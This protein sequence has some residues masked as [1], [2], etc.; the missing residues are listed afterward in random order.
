MAPRIALLDVRVVLLVLAVAL[1][2]PVGALT[3]DPGGGRTLAPVAF[4]DT[5]RTG[6]TGVDVRQATAAGH[7]IPRAEVFYS[8]YRYV[9]GYYGMAALVDA[10]SEDGHV[11][12]FGRPLAVYVT[13]YAGTDPR[14]TSEDR[15]VLASSVA[16]DWTRASEA[17]YVVD[18]RARHPAGSAVLAFSERERANAFAERAAGRVVDW[19]TLRRTAR[20]AE[21]ELETAM[22]AAVAEQRAWANATVAA[23]ASLT[24]RPVSTVVG[25]DAPTLA[26]AVARAPPNTT[27]RVPPGT[28]AANLTVDKPITI[29]GAGNATRLAGDGNGTVLTLRA[30][31]SAVTDLRITGIGADNFGEPGDGDADGAWDQRVRLVYGR[32]D[33]GIRL[34]GADRSLVRN[35]TLSTPANGVV[36]FESTHAV[37]TDVTV[38]GTDRP[39]EG[40]MGVLP[41]GSRVVVQNTT[42]RGGRDGIYTHY[43]TGLVVRNNDVRGMRYGFH[44]MYTSG[45]L[46]ANNTARETTSGVILMTRPSGNLVVENDVR[47][48]EA[49]IIT[50]GSRS[51]V[52]RNVLVEN[53][54][55]LSVGTDRSVV[56]ENTVVGNE[57]G[58]RS[59]TLL[60]TN[61]VIAND[62]VANDRAVDL[63]RGPLRVWAREGRGN[64]WG[65]VPGVD[66]D[67]DGTVDRPYR[68]ASA[69]DAAAQHHGG[70]AALTRSPAVVALRQFQQTVPG[71]RPS[72]LVDPAPLQRPA[73]P[74]VLA[75]ARQT[76]AEGGA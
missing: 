24:E 52:A 8:Q 27:V 31:R 33:A 20:P 54:I 13:D 14:L 49:G 21:P 26:A 66:R 59:D 22:T 73:R 74:E 43:A 75:R 62:V 5:L 50:V 56:T 4:D 38:L 64:Y 69:L 2:V 16:K 34:D 9:M 58:V 15:V 68:P 72:G 10:L 19:Q 1:V 25:R 17:Y 60:P 51:Y 61:T 41:M 45:A 11:A 29:A 23:R 18:S 37:V 63:G 28:Y 47:R 7:E 48:S 12:S 6:L 53:G 67:G 39:T 57:L 55:G 70:P 3:L 35:V 42:V 44:E 71:M 65:P 46:F 76:T 30:P 40:A 32:G 36:L